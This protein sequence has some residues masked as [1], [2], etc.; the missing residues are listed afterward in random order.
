MRID[1]LI[2]IILI[3]ILLCVYCFIEFSFRGTKTCRLENENVQNRGGKWGLNT[4]W[5]NRPRG[6]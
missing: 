4:R 3:L 6:S 1:Y 5:E 2:I